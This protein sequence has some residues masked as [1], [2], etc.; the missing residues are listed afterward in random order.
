MKLQLTLWI[1]IAFLLT[2]LCRAADPPEHEAIRQYRAYVA[3][4]R[5][6]DVQAIQKL[7]VPVSK[8]VQPV[9]AALIKLKILQERLYNATV[10]Q[11]GPIDFKKEEL[12]DGFGQP[13]DDDLKDIRAKLYEKLN[14]A[15]LLLKNPLTG[16]HDVSA[17][18]V[19]RNNKWFV[20]I[21]LQHDEEDDKKP[22]RE[23]DAEEREGMLKYASKMNREI[24]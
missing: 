23:P 14:V 13:S 21:S 5:A 2:S 1:A 4:V 16:D 24:E 6:G 19:G 9:Q 18:M 22:P 20:P 3:A 10:A 17:L 15:Q 7:V 12:W 8:P 11:F